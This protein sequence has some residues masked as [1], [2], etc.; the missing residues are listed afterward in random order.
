MTVVLDASA[1][2][3]LIKGEPGHRRVSEALAGTAAMTT[4]NFAEVA[5]WIARRNGNE[6]QIRSVLSDLS[7]PLTAVDADLAVHMGLLA[8][9]TAKSG[10][11]LGD[12]AC[13]AL[14]RRMDAP[15]LTSDRNWA[16]V[17]AA[18]GVEVELIR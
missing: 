6:R 18:A 16:E 5:T 12:R 2:I 8:R 4:I 1:L 15:A 14:A 17:A 10:L 3:A 13:L 7:F 9:L 11:S